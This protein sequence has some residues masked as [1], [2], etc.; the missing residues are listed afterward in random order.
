MDRGEIET[1]I[2]RVALNDCAA[3]DLLY[4][5]VSSKLFGVCLRVLETSVEAE[6]ALQDTFVKIWLH[7]DRYK[8]NGLSPMTWLITI[9]RNTSLDRLRARKRGHRDTVPLIYEIAATGPGVEQSLVNAAELKHLSNCLDRLEDDCGSAIRGV[10]L[11]NY[12]YSEIADRFN[13]PINTMR[14]RLRRG[15]IKLRKYVED[16]GLHPH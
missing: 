2:T 5:K 12:T 11:D 14:T 1:L 10:Y 15:L 4:D 8:V 16:T 7:A 9:A 13:V 3:F 6:D